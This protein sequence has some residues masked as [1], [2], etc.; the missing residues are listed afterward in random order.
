MSYRIVLLLHFSVVCKR[1]HELR[2][3]VV[4]P[5]FR[6]GMT[7]SYLGMQGLKI[8]AYGHFIVDPVLDFKFT[9]DS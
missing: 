1:A 2:Y 6:L 8:N 9:L 5:G 7:V 4:F 3:S